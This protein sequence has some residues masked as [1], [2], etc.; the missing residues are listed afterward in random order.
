LGR[1]GIDSIF[2]RDY[3]VIIGITFISGI[4]VIVGNLISDIF[5]LLIDPR[6]R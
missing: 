2:A 6:L 4:L 1:I 5:N 3:P